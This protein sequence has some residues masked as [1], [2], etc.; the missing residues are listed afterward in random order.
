VSP[1]PPDLDHFRQRLNLRLP[2]C[3]SG[4]TFLYRYS[5][6]WSCFVD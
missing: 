1:L 6:R 4:P 3:D 5:G 2:N